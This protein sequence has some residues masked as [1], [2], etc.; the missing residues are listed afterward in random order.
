[1]LRGYHGTFLF[2]DNL[3]GMNFDVHDIPAWLVWFTIIAAHSD[4][5]A[6]VKVPEHDFTAAQRR[7]VEFTPPWV[8]KK[9]VE[10]PDEEL[11]WVTAAPDTSE[12]PYLYITGEPGSGF[13]TKEAFESKD[14]EHAGPIIEQYATPG[15]PHDQ[16]IRLDESGE[17]T[18]Y[19][20]DYPIYAA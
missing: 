12:L 10:I 20:L 14:A 15:I 4:L 1:M 7:E 16:L 17:A 9:V 3:L 5:V 19:P 11:K 2:L 6:F 8:H 18:F 13:V